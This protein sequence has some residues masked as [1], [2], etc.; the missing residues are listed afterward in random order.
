V[1]QPPAQQQVAR[2]CLVLLLLGMLLTL[3]LV[4]RVA[5]RLA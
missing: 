1:Q 2:W 4:L 3:I 5:L